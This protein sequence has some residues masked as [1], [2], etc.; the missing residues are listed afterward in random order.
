MIPDKSGSANKKSATRE[1]REHNQKGTLKFENV[2]K[3]ETD[4]NSGYIRYF[5]GRCG[6]ISPEVHLDGAF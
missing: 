2:E 6:E 1:N 3:M 4:Q 5:S